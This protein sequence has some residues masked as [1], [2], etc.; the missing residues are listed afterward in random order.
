MTAFDNS[1]SS[2]AIRGVFA[3]AS[4]EGCAGLRLALAAALLPMML[5]AC[6]GPSE[7]EG[8][9]VTSVG[10]DNLAAFVPSDEPYRAGA[11]HFRRGEYGL[12]QRHFLE[13]TDRAPRDVKSWIGLAASY[14]RLRRFDLADKAYSNAIAIAGET[15]QILNN[16]GYS[17]MLRGNLSAARA[18][19][20]QACKLEPDNP[21]VRNNMRLLENGTK[22][23]K[24][25]HG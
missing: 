11:L 9:V 18:K 16:Q 2:G 8:Y 14:D 23:I 20:D 25:G 17:Y 6:A 1:T 22:Y 4:C 7:T 5:V 12:A 13:A 21:L 19:F 15:V 10:E 24:P 3:R